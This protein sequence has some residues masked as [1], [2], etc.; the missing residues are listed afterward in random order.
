M[1]PSSPSSAQPPISDWTPQ[2]LN[3]DIL[4]SIGL[5]GVKLLLPSNSIIPSPSF[6]NHWHWAT[7]TPGTRQIAKFHS[8]SSFVERWNGWRESESH[9]PLEGRG[10]PSRL[11]L[12]WML[13]VCVLSCPAVCSRGEKV[14]Y[15]ALDGRPRSLRKVL[16]G[17][18]KGVSHIFFDCSTVISVPSTWDSASNG[19]VKERQ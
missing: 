14:E 8:S 16:F 12:L 6:G 9:M 18:V 2:K 1:I 3:T 5:T 10:F 7:S 19:Q 15:V 17:K 11:L 13:M 4:H